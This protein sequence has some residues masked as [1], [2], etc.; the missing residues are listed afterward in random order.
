M[1]TPIPEIDKKP[2]MVDRLTTAF[3]AAGKRVVDHYRS[4]SV[5]AQWDNAVE[6]VVG[7]YHPEFTKEQIAEQAKRFHLLAQSMGVAASTMDLT[8]TAFG[9]WKGGDT[10]LSIRRGNPMQVDP[11][12]GAAIIGIGQKDSGLG[13][14]AQRFTIGSSLPAFGLAAGA[15]LLRPARFL[16]ELMG[17]GAGLGG[18]KV[19][20]I[21]RRITQGS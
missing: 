2:S 1:E 13:S 20:G 8:L 6:R 14:R 15:T 10:V 4:D 19:G 17:K 3:K 18:G 16:L 9:V 21:I 5:V 11:G 12:S 7:G